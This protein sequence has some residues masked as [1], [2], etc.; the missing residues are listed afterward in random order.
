MT[1]AE[2]YVVVVISLENFSEKLLC[3]NILMSINLN[4]IKMIYLI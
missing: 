4:L 3:K 2:V 1:A